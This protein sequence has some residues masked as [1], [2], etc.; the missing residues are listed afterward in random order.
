MFN[1]QIVDTSTI[2]DLINLQDITLSDNQVVDLQPF[3]NNSGI[4]NGDEI[5]LENNPLSDTSKN[6][7]IPQLGVMGVS[8][9]Q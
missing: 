3:V 7:Y 8:G 1:N 2:M 4:N 6:I 5:W 9:H